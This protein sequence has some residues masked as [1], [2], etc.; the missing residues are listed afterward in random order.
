[1]PDGFLVSFDG[2]ARALRFART[3]R[4]VLRDQLRLEIRAGAHTG[5]CARAGDKLSGPAVEIGLAVLL[6]AQA[7]EVLATSAVKDLGVG[8]GIE[9]RELGAQV[10]QGVPG[11]WELYALED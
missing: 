2:P 5:E 3:V 9:L 8:S 6:V 11:L 7:G 4:Q 10:L 1:V